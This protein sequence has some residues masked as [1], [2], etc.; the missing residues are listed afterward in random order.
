MGKRWI[1][2]LLAAAALL[3]CAC[4]DE[5][6]DTQPTRDTQPVVE[7]TQPEILQ[8]PTVGICLPK[9]DTFWKKQG[10]LLEKH[11]Q[12]IGYD[13]IVE[14][15]ACDPGVQKN[16]METLIS[17]Q[18]DALIVTAVDSYA[19]T[20]GVQAAQKAGI[21]VVA[22]DR[23]PMYTDGVAFCVQPDSFG[24]GQLLASYIIET[25]LTE[26]NRKK[27]VE[28][29][30]GA[31]DNESSLAFYNGV[32]ANLQPYLDSGALV[33]RSGRTGFED[34]A[35]KNDSAQAAFE[36]CYDYLD[37]YY[38]KHKLDILLCATDTF[39]EGCIY[40]LEQFPKQLEKGYPVIL[41]VGGEAGAVAHIS[42]KNQET[43]L[44]LDRNMQA[45]Q[46]AKLTYRLLSGEELPEAQLRSN[47]TKNVKCYYIDPTLVDTAN[48]QQ[49]MMDTG[50]YAQI[51]LDEAMQAENR[52]SVSLPTETRP[53]LPDPP[54]K[55][56]VPTTDTRPPSTT[57][58]TQPSET[59]PPETTAPPATQP[60]LPPNVPPL[61]L[62]TS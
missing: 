38:D 18:V 46:C 57:T 60:T 52:P 49:T 62:P 26:P 20:D 16:Q 33:C 39:A 47:G 34:V 35:V 48:Y 14:Y 43:T 59:S 17:R 24:M 42:L 54:T 51:Q 30:M 58:E 50:I 21:P 61:T 19:L 4:N 1:A 22:Y 29:L 6:V 37:E 53:G 28:F 25:Q 45:L 13:T 8:Q 36:Q 12:D 41:G 15:A 27:T 11:L 31:T 7:A 9:E 3:L 10:A 40:A 55:P 5:Q 2:A 56:P 23:L 44:Y 32:M